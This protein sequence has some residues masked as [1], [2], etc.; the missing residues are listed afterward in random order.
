MC[1]RRVRRASRERNIHLCPGRKLLQ[2]TA[3]IYDSNM[4]RYRA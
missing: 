1:Y 4:Q 2:T 3:T